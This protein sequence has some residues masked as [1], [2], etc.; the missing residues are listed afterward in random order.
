MVFRLRGRF[1]A[2]V[3]VAA[4]TSVHA[5][6]QEST[7]AADRH[8]T[9]DSADP[10]ATAG[11]DGSNLGRA[12]GMVMLDYQV[13]SV[14]QQKSIDLM[15]LHVLTKLNDW[16]YV[17]VG[18]YAPMFN[19]EYG[20]FMAFD[21]IAHAQRR[22]WRNLFANAGL[23]VGG[24]G[25]GKSMEQSKLLS[26]TGGFVKGY[27]GLGYDFTDFS[28][29]A[30][31]ARM[32]FKES[33][34]DNTQLNVFVQVPFSYSIGPYASFGE[35]LA[36]ADARGLFGDSSETTL[37]LGLDNFV[38]IDPEGSN[39]STIRLTELQFAHYMSS[40]AYWYANLAIGYKGLPLYNQII[41]GLGYRFN[42]SPR[43]NLHG[44]LGVGSGGWAPDTIDTGSGL[45][46][47]PRVAVEHAIAKNL[48]LSL[49]AGYL[50]APKGSSKNYTFGAALNYHVLSGREG[51]GSGGASAG[52]GYLGY[53][54]S[55]FPQTG[56]NVSRRDIDRPRINMLSV[57]FD[58]LV[59]DHVYIPIKGAAAYNAYLGYPGYGELLAGVGVQS[60]YRK[61]DRLQFF[62]QVLGGA[63]V[64]GAIAQ[65]GVGINYGLSDR[66]AVYASAGKTRS[67]SSN[68]GDFRS[69]YVGLG[70]TYRFSVPS[71]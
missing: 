37:S 33:A 47:Y 52:I 25:G 63:N 2:P 29:G 24:G 10:P 8:G 11:S 38:Q 41:G 57:Q 62:G 12:E 56:F 27:V 71:R 15:G 68:D 34:I 58:S 18:A 65:A 43:V 35:K 3:V 51:T 7:P 60:K 1:L 14:P 31:V 5:A 66:L 42:V 30:N 46:I 26:G 54:L 4:L 61:G 49:S 44:Q 39:K 6:A 70:M 20:G 69:D 67:I 23:S 36:D 21:V 9:S 64:H 19:G 32:K 16:M 45:L 40:N 48:S 55:L 22:I 59:S 50:F 13:I 28:V 17:G 53:R